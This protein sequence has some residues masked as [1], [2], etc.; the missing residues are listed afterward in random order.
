[1]CMYEEG[2]IRFFVALVTDAKSLSRRGRQE[3][4]TRRWRLSEWKSRDAFLRLRFWNFDRSRLC[5]NYAEFANFEEE[6]G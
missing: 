3:R 2:T 6:R 5:I 4:W 1:M